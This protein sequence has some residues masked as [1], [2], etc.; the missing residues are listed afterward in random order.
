MTTLATSLYTHNLDHHVRLLIVSDAV[1]IGSTLDAL[2]QPVLTLRRI[3]RMR[4]RLELRVLALNHLQHSILATLLIAEIMP[5]SHDQVII[6]DPSTIVLD[7]VSP[8]W[9]GQPKAIFESPYTSHLGMTPGVVRVDLVRLRALST[10]GQ[11][12]DCSAIARAV[13]TSLGSSTKTPGQ[14]GELQ[15]QQV[16]H[17]RMAWVF[18]ELKRW[19]AP[20]GV[21]MWA[22][23]DCVWAYT[24]LP[25]VHELTV[26]REGVPY[27]LCTTD[28]VHQAFLPLHRRR[29]AEA[30]GPP[31]TVACG[32]GERIRILAA[33]SANAGLSQRAYDAMQQAWSTLSSAAFR[34]DPHA[35]AAVMHELIAHA[36]RHAAASTRS[37][38]AL[39]NGS[40]ATTVVRD[41]R[42]LS[43]V[44]PPPP[45][46]GGV[47]PLIFPCHAASVEFHW[48]TRVMMRG[49]SSGVRE[50]CFEELVGAHQRARWDNH[51]SD[52]GDL[53]ELL[54]DKT[55][56]VLQD[57]QYDLAT[58]IV[59]AAGYSTSDLA[60]VHISHS[61]MY[62]AEAPLAV[63]KYAEWRVA[64]RNNEFAD[65]YDARSYDVAGL[66]APD[67][68]ANDRSTLRDA[69]RQ[70]K[71][72]WYPLGVSAQWVR[73]RPRDA[74]DE[75]PATVA[76]SRPHFISFLG[77]TDK[78]DREARVAAV[79]AALAEAV[80]GRAQMLSTHGHHSCYDN[81]C[82]NTDY[83][84]A[85]RGS[86]LSL[87][88][89][90]SSADSG[91]LW[92][93]LE[94]G[95]IP[96]VVESFGPGE[97]AVGTDPLYGAPAIRATRDALLPLV[98]DLGGKALPFVVVPDVES[99]VDELRRLHDDQ[100]ALDEV[101]EAT[102]AW[103]RS[104]KAFYAQRFQDALCD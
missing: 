68:R 29:I 95:C 6:M 35:A 16:E 46:R 70:G 41:V 24:P 93:A 36:Q 59:R 50:V 7:D 1:S 60:F 61:L 72:F 57:A 51:Q 66:A 27:V 23:I 2:A 9:R 89:P 17:E 104:V 96:V 3:A 40:T 75:L 98:D 25:H 55:V 45:C 13:Q 39:F 77:S 76:S 4:G 103:W 48:L 5:N 97:A 15:Y 53:E 82:N 19:S 71:V 90:G 58:M 10:S 20:E 21:E 43:A 14:A 85:M 87:H 80:D 63:A 73:L 83:V 91:R 81:A 44:R 86:A 8:L 34:S 88:L 65:S 54:C 101:Q 11:I 92:E 32:C 62:Q 84:D 78:S 79:R 69:R 42:A 102:R 64:F 52:A 26:D 94:A 56:L 100:G 49:C 30:Y 74:N 28:L 12:R 37:H 47:T 33:I 99:L 38:F 67:E 18:T 22:P 31:S